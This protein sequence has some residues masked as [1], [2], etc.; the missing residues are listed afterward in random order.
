MKSFIRKKIIIGKKA[1]SLI[2][3]SVAIVILSIVVAGML[4]VSTNA[5]INDKAKK[6]K[7]N[8]DLIY[9]ALGVYLLKNGSMPCPAPITSVKSTDADYG[10]STGNSGLCANQDGVY[11]HQN[12]VY[13]MVP[14]KNLGLPSDVAEDGFGNKFGYLIYNKFTSV[15]LFGISSSNAQGI[16]IKNQDTSLVAS[17]EL[18]M[19]AIIS[20]GANKYGAF[21]ANSA[22]Q[23]S[24]S[25]LAAE[26]TN[27]PTSLDNLPVSPL[28]NTATF[29]NSTTNQITIN[30]SSATTS[31]VFDDIVFFKTRNDMVRDFNA[32]FLIKCP[33]VTASAVD[34]NAVSFGGTYFAWTKSSGTY[35]YG[36]EYGEAA[37]S[38]TE[39]PTGWKKTVKWPTRRCGAFGQWEAG[40]TN[41]SRIAAPCTQ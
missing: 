19:F 1:F 26:Q 9:S 15:S 3:L 37:T 22:T 8:I 20:Y 5:V 33:V 11:S 2:E 40:G 38:N 16:D 36:G 34:A 32:L 4:S 24:T 28:P 30:A 10:Y 31:S 21:N 13:G 41:P 39:C 29:S 27:Y 18:A 23:N 6:T 17:T 7:D 14:I 12:S 35:V 25:T